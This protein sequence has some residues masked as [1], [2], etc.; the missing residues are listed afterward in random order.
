MKAVCFDLLPM[1][2]P[3]TDIV[4]RALPGSAD[5]SWDTLQKEIIRA[6]SKVGKR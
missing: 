5:I 3:G 2:S 6:V 4:I 1:V